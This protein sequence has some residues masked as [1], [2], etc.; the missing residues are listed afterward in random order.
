MQTSKPDK[1]NQIRY[2]ASLFFVIIAI[3]NLVNSFVSTSQTA[4]FD[5]T[6]LGVAIL[7][8]LIKKR[9][10][11]LG[12]GVLATLVSFPILLIYLITSSTSYLVSYFFGLSVFIM[13]L[14]CSL[15]LIYVG[16]YSPEKGRFKLV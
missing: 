16:T 2:C 10:F 4:F 6:F 9:I 3:V 11:I 12:Y 15:A 1:I 5:I 14:V 13:A 7:P 8:M